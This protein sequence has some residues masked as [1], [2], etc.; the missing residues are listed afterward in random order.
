MVKGSFIEGCWIWASTV[1]GMLGAVLVATKLNVYMGF[2]CYLAS[3]I[4]L[5][6][7]ARQRRITAMLLLQAFYTGV[8]ILGI[9][10]WKN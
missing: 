5:T 10:T 1:L 9:V 8:N 2:C 3:S 6:V 4:I 7:W